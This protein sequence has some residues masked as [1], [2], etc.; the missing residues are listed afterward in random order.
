MRGFIAA[1]AARRQ[2]NDAFLRF[3]ETLEQ[4]VHLQLLE[5]REES[6]LIGA[7]NQARLDVKRFQTDWHDPQFVQVTQDSHV[8]AVERWNV[9]GTPTLVFPNGNSI[10]L[11]LNEMPR[12]AN[13]L[14]TFQVFEMLA[15]MPPYIRQFR[16][17]S[18][19]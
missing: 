18:F 9:S 11:E 7:A 1:E 6:T 10:H 2:G 15:V 16:H 14:K 12:D 13:A 19:H 3:H 4:A 5:L 8:Q 17:S